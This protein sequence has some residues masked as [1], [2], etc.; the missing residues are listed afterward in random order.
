VRLRARA[1]S[2]LLAVL[3]ALCGCAS[4]YPVARPS[5]SLSHEIE[6]HFTSPRDVTARMRRGTVEQLSSVRRLRGRPVTLWLDT[7]VLSTGWYQSDRKWRSF[8][9]PAL[10][11]V[12]IAE[13]EV[14]LSERRVSPW[15]TLAV[16]VIGT[17]VAY[18]IL[19]LILYATTYSAAT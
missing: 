9:E 13:S 18:K 17:Y 3:T 8:S 7:L 10:V 12:P 15:D 16:V 6:V 14:R 5:G 1:L 11:R 4:Y 19:I 2:A